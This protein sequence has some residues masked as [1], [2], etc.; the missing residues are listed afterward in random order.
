MGDTYV[1]ATPKRNRSDDVDGGEAKKLLLQ[2][3]EA[4]PAAALASARH[5]FGE[6]GG[7]NMSIEASATFTVMEPETMRRMFAGELGPDRDFFIYSRHFNP[8]VLSLSRLMAALEGTEAAY[9]TASGMSAISAVLLQL[10]SH[11]EHV[12]ASRTLYGGTHAL[13]SHFLPR[14]C[15]ISTSFVEVTDL[16]MVD[17][18]IVEGKTKVLYF[19][20]VSNPT[21]T[22]ANIPEL[23][24]MAHRKGVTVVVDNTFA[25]MVLSP[26]RLGA[27]VVVHSISKFISGGADIIAGAV[28]GPARL[29]NAMMDL[30]Q[31]SLMLLGPTMNAKVAFELSERIPHLGLRMKEHSNRALEFATRLK[32]LGMRV[33]YPGLEEHP[34]HQ[35]LKSMHNKDYGYGGLMCVDM[36]TEE[37][38]NRFMSHLQNYGQFGF[39]AVSLGYYETLMSCSGSS[40]SSELSTEEKE[41]AGISPGLVRMSIGYIGTLEQKWSQLQK[42]LTRLNDSGYNKIA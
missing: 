4:D 33:I 37:R 35:L 15:G 18:A 20:S 28:C 31:G 39:M 6:H 32:R 8:T 40:T 30:Q 13:L 9:C 17:A 24:H 23:C 26:A 21:L 7:V 27:D 14:T 34:Q 1:L 36:E 38:A 11:G 16:D 19:E 22:V 42:A 41:L 29:V 5:E 3:G 10:C 2:Q 12:V 25:P